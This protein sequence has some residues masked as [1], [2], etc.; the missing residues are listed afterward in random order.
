MP[1]WSDDGT[2]VL[3][4][5][6][7]GGNWD[8]YAQPADGS[9]PAEALLQRALDQFPVAMLP[10]GTLLYAEVTPTTG[11]DLWI[12]SP[13][14]QPS[15]LRVTPFNE[16]GAQLSPGAGGGPRWLAYTS[17]REMLG[18]SNGALST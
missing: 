4:A 6:D 3:F 13:G 10:D 5:S 7:R 8:I 9:R 17:R 15:P 11:R 18:A 1:L 16:M 12:L 2:R 14:A